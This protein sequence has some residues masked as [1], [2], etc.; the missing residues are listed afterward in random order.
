MDTNW[1]I[2]GTACG[3]YF[4]FDLETEAARRPSPNKFAQVENGLHEN[5]GRVNGELGRKNY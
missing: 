4:L 5:V 1:C 2:I 3:E